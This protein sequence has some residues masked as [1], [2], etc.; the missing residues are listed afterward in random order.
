MWNALI[1]RGIST[2][3]LLLLFFFCVYILL[4]WLLQLTSQV[5]ILIYFLNP[6]KDVGFSSDSINQSTKFILPP[7]SSH[8]TE[9]RKEVGD[10]LQMWPSSSS[11]R[12]KEAQY[13]DFMEILKAPLLQI[14]HPNLDNHDWL[15]EM[16]QQCKQENQKMQIQWWFV[17]YKSWWFDNQFLF[18]LW[19]RDG[20]IAICG[21]I[22][23]FRDFRGHWWM[24]CQ[25]HRCFLGS[26]LGAI[27]FG[28]KVF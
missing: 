8:W 17:S 6:W 5:L 11:P 14:K 4:V 22:L 7:S 13:R 21:P 26:F 10:C 28:W 24:P 19:E 9:T 25:F 20:C 3:N 18:L 12:R 1:R 16:K 2:H 27:A 15:F 23:R